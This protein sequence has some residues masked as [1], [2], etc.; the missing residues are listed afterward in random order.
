MTSL[1]RTPAARSGSEYLEYVEY[2]RRRFMYARRRLVHVFL[3]RATLMARSLWQA[4]PLATKPLADRD[5]YM[6]LY[7]GARNAAYPDIDQYER[8][9]AFVID[10]P[11]L[12]NL[13]LHTQVVVKDSPLMWP[14]G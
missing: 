8:E 9:T 13:A 14:H 4:A 12:D 7:E 1:T 10:R 5:T 6:R 2:F 11:F 3:R